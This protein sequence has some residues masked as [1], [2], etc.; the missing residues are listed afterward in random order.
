L[1]KTRFVKYF[2]WYQPHVILFETFISSNFGGVCLWPIMSPCPPV[3]LLLW[4]LISLVWLLHVVTSACYNQCFSLLSWNMFAVLCKLARGV[5]PSCWL[6]SQMNPASAQK[7][8]AGGLWDRTRLLRTD[9][10][11]CSTFANDRVSLDM[12]VH[13]HS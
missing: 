3:P 13:N 2:W 8:S 12:A 6:G 9:Q 1:T 7:S 10:R 5:V 4:Q 11:I